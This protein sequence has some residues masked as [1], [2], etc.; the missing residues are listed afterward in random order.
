MLD[1]GRR[2]LAVRALE[3]AVFDDSHRSVR[4]AEQV[5][6]RADRHGEFELVM[7]AH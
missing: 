7:R 3:I 6:S 4:Y 2:L 5:I 1:C